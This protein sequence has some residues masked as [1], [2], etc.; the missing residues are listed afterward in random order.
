M[1]YAPPALAEP[2]TSIQVLV[3]GRAQ[4][5]EVAAT[6]FVPQRYFRKPSFPSGA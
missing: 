4:P 3:R 2:G 1:G 6:P 5:A